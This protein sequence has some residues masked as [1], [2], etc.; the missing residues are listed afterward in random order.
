[1]GGFSAITLA[2]IPMPLKVNLPMV[3]EIDENKIPLN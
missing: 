3:K 1:V 2:K